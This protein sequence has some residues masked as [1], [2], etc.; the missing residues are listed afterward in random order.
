PP[1]TPRGRRPSSRGVAGAGPASGP[2]RPRAR[3]GRSRRE[4]CGFEAACDSPG[5][6]ADDDAKPDDD[7]AQGLDRLL[8]ERDR[9]ELDQALGGEIERPVAAREEDLVE[10]G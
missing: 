1:P 10:E 5:Q 3:A 6:Q 8:P 7:D 2:A 4:G 9:I